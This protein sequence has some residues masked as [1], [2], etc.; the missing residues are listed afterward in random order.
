M[1]PFLLQFYIRHQFHYSFHT[2]QARK[3]ICRY[4]FSFKKDEAESL[5]GNY[6]NLKVK[7]V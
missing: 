6:E 4:C 1:T 3:G 2:T 5:T 7:V